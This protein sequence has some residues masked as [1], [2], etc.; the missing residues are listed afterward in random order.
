MI[1]ADTKIIEIENLPED[2]F[3]RMTEKDNKPIEKDGILP[4]EEAEKR[5]IIQTLERLG[6]NKLLTARHLN[7]ATTTLYRK[8]RMYGIE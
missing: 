7:I 5:H 8:L 3:S 2:L 1:F 6:G 4:L